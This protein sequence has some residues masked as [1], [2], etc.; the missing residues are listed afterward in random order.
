M[1]NCV[2]T[3]KN[4]SVKSE[5]LFDILMSCIKH[6]QPLYIRIIAN[7]I[8]LTNIAYFTRS[9]NNI[10]RAISVMDFRSS[11]ADRGSHRELDQTS[12]ARQSACNLFVCSPSSRHPLPR[13]ENCLFDSQL[14]RRYEYRGRCRSRHCIAAIRWTCRANRWCGT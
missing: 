12:H 7:Y 8:P 1:V 11:C 2:Q 10:L 6:L 13:S 5:I 3:E 4:C 9:P 14:L